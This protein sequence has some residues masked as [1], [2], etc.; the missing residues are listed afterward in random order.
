MLPLGPGFEIAPEASALDA[1]HRMNEANSGR[2]IVID[3]G[4]M[5]GFITPPASRVSSRSRRSLAAMP[6]L[7][8]A[9]RR[10]RIPELRIPG[11]YDQK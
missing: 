5:V 2:L 7:W 8:R 11:L 3:G 9:E 4:K 10:E 1:I 6:M